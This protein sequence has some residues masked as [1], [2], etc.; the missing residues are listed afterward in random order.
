MNPSDQRQLLIDIEQMNEFVLKVGQMHGRDPVDAMMMLLV[1]AC[2][3]YR[4]FANDPNSLSNL[5]EA[6]DKAMEA[7]NS[8][9][10]PDDDKHGSSLQ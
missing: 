9:W 4:E 5:H 8:W 6:V 3:L 10:M 1:G 7:A 2:Q